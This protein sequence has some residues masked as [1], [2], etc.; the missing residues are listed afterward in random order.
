MFW[1][2]L[3]YVLCWLQDF[4]NYVGCCGC[5]SYVGCRILRT[6]LVVCPMFGTGYWKIETH[7]GVSCCVGLCGLCW[8]LDFENYIGCSIS[9]PMLG[10][11]F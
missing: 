1:W 8:F 10:A 9:V 3:L 6:M 11:R 4:G 2:L 5:I 7:V